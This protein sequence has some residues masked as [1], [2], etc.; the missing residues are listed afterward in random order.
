LRPLCRTSVQRRLLTIEAGPHVSNVFGPEFPL[1]FGL[2]KDGCSRPRVCFSCA[3]SRRPSRLGS[4]S[5]AMIPVFAPRPLFF[6]A[7]RFCK[8]LFDDL[9]QRGEVSPISSQFHPV[10][11]LLLTRVRPPSPFS[12]G[13]SHDT[14]CVH[15]QVFS[16]T[17]PARRTFFSLLPACLSFG[18][19]ECM[20][21]PVFPSDLNGPAHFFLYHRQF[22]AS[23]FL[24]GRSKCPS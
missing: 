4:P 24:S 22:L 16:D 8:V 15:S 13:G 7:V 6:R 3:F 20:R 11:S 19:P 23:S 17:C 1:P 14:S 12:A 9:R 2:A 5:R 18:S 10:L 21:A